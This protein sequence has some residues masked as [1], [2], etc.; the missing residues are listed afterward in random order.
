MQALEGEAIIEVISIN[1][2][3]D[4]SKLTQLSKLIENPHHRHHETKASI[5]IA[6]TKAPPTYSTKVKIHPVIV[7]INLES[8]LPLARRI[9]IVTCANPG[10]V[11][12]PSSTASTA[13]SSA[14]VARHPS[15]CVRKWEKLQQRSSTYGGALWRRESRKEEKEQTGCRPAATTV[16][17]RHRRVICALATCAWLSMQRRS[18]TC[19]KLIYIRTSSSL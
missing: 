5:P 2:N 1:Q 18:R 9:S 14:R 10:N 8:H 17:L 16:G 4:D 3:A 6:Q 7:S 19:K 15:V 13:C 11:L 12:A